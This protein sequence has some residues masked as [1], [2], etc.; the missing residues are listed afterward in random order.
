[1]NSPYKIGKCYT[2]KTPTVGLEFD[3]DD[4][5]WLQSYISYQ[6]GF[7]K[8]LQDGIDYLEKQEEIRKNTEDE[9]IAIVISERILQ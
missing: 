1:M 9:G 2:A 8:D 7:H 5:Y 6:N 4:S 3:L